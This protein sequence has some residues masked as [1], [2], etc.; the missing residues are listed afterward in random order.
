ME[1]IEEREPNFLIYYTEAKPIDELMDR[2]PTAHQ[3][4]LQRT[5]SYL[6]SRQTIQAH[7]KTCATRCF[8]LH[9]SLLSYRVDI[10]LQARSIEEKMRKG[11]YYIFFKLGIII[12]IF[13]RK[14]KERINKGMM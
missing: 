9:G 6:A 12:Y 10:Y 5:K 2:N 8:S 4:S 3:Q 11:K 14:D 1:L 13:E 7:H